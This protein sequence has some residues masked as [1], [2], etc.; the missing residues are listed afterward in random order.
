MTK[1]NFARIK[2]EMEDLPILN[3]KGRVKNRAEFRNLFKGVEVKLFG[4]E[5]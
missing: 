1:N 5:E 3:S 2:V 4:E